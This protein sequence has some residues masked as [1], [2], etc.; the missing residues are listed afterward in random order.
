MRT[1]LAVALCF[2]L[3]ACAGGPDVFG[4]YDYVSINGETLPMAAVTEGW[5]ELRADG[6]LGLSITLPNQ[7][8]PMVYEGEFSLGEMEDGCIPYSSPDV[9]DPDKIWTGSICG[10]VFTNESAGT[11]LVLHKRR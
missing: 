5:M 7:P 6:S 4:T 9:E 10:D 3:G 1:V 11:T 2:V 8:D